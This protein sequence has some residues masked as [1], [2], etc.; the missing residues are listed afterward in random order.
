M[1]LTVSPIPPYQ[2]LHRVHADVHGIHVIDRHIA[3]LEIFLVELER[4]PCAS[5]EEQC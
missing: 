3:L 2:L 5:R 1:K 4:V